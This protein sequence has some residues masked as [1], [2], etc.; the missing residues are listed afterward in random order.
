MN[1]LTRDNLYDYQR[2]AVQHIHDNPKC[3]LWVDMGLGK[4]VS[5]LTAFAD[6]YAHFDARRMLVVAPLRV[7]RD[8]WD[9]EIR[10]WAHLND[11]SVS[12][13]VGGRQARLDAL[14]VPADI[15]TINRENL[16]WLFSG[17]VQEITK[18]RFRQIRKWPWDWIVL[19]ESQSFKNPSAV[20]TK[21]ASR[22]STFG[23][24]ERIIE[25]TGTPSP[26]GYLDI[27]SQLFV[28]DHGQRLGQTFDAYKKRWFDPP[29]DWGF[30]WTL[31]EFA[32]QAIQERIGDLILSMR[33]EDYLDLPPVVYNEIKVTLSPA[34]M[35]KYKKLE[36][37]ALI[38]LDPHR[39]TAANAGVL[40]NKLLQLSAGA[41]YV[42]DQGSY[43]TLHDVKLDALCDALDELT[44]S[45]PV[46]IG[47]SFKS[48]ARRISE[49]LKKYCGKSQS[50]EFL[51]SAESLKRFE[52]GEI[53]YG[54]IHPGSAGHGLNSLHL[55]GSENI[56][57]FGPT[58][59]LEWWDQLNAR[60]AGGHRRMGKN[61]RIQIILARDTADEDQMHSLRVKDGDQVGLMRALRGRV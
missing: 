50:W 28:L 8:V 4:T 5:T 56:I 33:A 9:D 32:E 52:K 54:V 14:R 15:H 44:F 6:A 27:W 11:L 18:S 22:I 20:R 26:N 48:D 1:I 2:R 30:K 55:S 12:K 23:L 16:Y 24:A 40:S 34:V 38:D 29:P 51:R 21:A 19:D 43:E 49:R 37:E 42:D 59:N 39:I 53:D 3:A 10:T 58:N 7:A 17:Y 47:H 61:V 46:L 36:R 13:I 57:W 35:R 31:K 25:L 41:M 45:G 60:I